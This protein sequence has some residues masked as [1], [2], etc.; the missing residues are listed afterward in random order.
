MAAVKDIGHPMPCRQWT[1]I[2][3]ARALSSVGNDFAKEGRFILQNAGLTG[4]RGKSFDGRV[5]SLSQPD[6][7]EDF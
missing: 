4:K 3:L 6:K 1:F 5:L 7:S 2:K